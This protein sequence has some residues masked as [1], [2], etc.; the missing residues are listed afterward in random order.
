MFSLF[1]FREYI[2]NH[3][4]Y[5]NRSD[6][7]IEGMVVEA[8]L[9]GDILTDLQRMPPWDFNLFQ[10]QE[11]ILLKVNKKFCRSPLHPPS[12]RAT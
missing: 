6:K 8:E 2:D 9:L 11:Y 10:N 3:I 5:S 12:K 1:T 7:S 4:K